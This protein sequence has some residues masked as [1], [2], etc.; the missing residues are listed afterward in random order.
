ML[1]YY[2]KSRYPVG[3]TTIWFLSGDLPWDHPQYYGFGLPTHHFI[4]STQLLRHK[5]NLVNFIV[6][7]KKLLRFTLK[8]KKN[9]LITEIT[10][11]FVLQLFSWT[12]RHMIKNYQDLFKRSFKWLFYLLCKCLWSE[13]LVWSLQ[14]NDIPAGR[15][16][17]KNQFEN[18][19]IQL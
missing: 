12:C 18:Y 17:P 10:F 14:I 9:L 16:L 2:F 3:P 13:C 15:T 6:Q 7:I 4:Q 19:L 5:C 11:C 8:F 1:K